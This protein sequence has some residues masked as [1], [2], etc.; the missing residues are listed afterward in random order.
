MGWL[1]IIPAFHMPPFSPGSSASQKSSKASFTR[2]EIDFLVDIGGSVIDLEVSFEWLNGTEAEAV[3]LVAQEMDAT[4][5][6]NE[7]V[8]VKTGVAEQAIKDPAAVS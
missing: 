3:Q 7:D 1:W 6:E 5:E 8:G 4:E 2:E